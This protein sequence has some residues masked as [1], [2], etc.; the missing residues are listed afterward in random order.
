VTVAA[1]AGLSLISSALWSTATTRILRRMVSVMSV[2]LWPRVRRTSTKSPGVTKPPT[3]VTAST[4]IATARVPGA[5]LSTMVT[6]CPK[7]DTLLAM[8]SSPR[9][10]G[11]IA[12]RAS[13]PGWAG[14]RA[15]K[16]VKAPAGSASAGQVWVMSMCGPMTSPRPISAAATMACTT[17]GCA[18]AS[19]C[20]AVSISRASCADPPATARPTRAMKIED[21]RI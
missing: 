13:P 21:R 3:D 2:S 16:S 12:R 7:A 5:R 17:A 11:R 8:T 15:A 19:A 4:R 18:A 20:G 9:A 1:S 6:F 14:R 10:M